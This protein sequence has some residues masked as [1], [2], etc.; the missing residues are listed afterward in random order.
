MNQVNRAFSLNEVEDLP[1]SYDSLQHKGPFPTAIEE[2]TSE[3]SP[4]PPYRQ[5][6]WYYERLNPTIMLHVYGRIYTECVNANV[7]CVTSI[8]LM[9]KLSCILLKCVL[10]LPN[11]IWQIP[12]R[13]CAILSKRNDASAMRFRTEALY[14][15]PHYV[16]HSSVTLGY[17][18]LVHVCCLITERLTA[19]IFVDA[20]THYHILFFALCDWYMAIRRHNNYPSKHLV[21]WKHTHNQ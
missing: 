7:E 6:L 3:E 1:P 21:I 8:N 9:P 20:Y 12:N 19:V 16:Q 14:A 15:N 11:A 17:L 5:V 13:S 2:E 4:P 10:Q 18:M